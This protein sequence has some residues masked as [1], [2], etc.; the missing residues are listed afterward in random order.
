MSSQNI[1]KNYPDYKTYKKKP[2]YTKPENDKLL[3]KKLEKIENDLKS[4]KH[5]KDIPILNS[6]YQMGVTK[7]NIP[8]Y[9]FYA[10]IPIAYF[11]SKIMFHYKAYGLYNKSTLFQ[12]RLKYFFGINFGFFLV[13]K[14]SGI[15]FQKRFR[16]FNKRGFE[17]YKFGGEN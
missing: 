17:E 1:S 6:S 12:S 14:F 9:Q 8:I 10:S 16:F 13:N 5:Y 2:F 11:L 7:E 4:Y 15:L 3:Q